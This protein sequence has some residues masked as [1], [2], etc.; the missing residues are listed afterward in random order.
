MAFILL[1]LCL[2]LQINLNLCIRRSNH[3]NYCNAYMCQII[4]GM[5]FYFG[6]FLKISILYG[7]A[8]PIASGTQGQ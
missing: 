6:F 7:D 4:S 2:H 3:D 5:H 1:P 8:V